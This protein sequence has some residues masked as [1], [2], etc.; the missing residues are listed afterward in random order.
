[1]NPL[2]NRNPLPNVTYSQ[3]Y[4]HVQYMVFQ[5][6]NSTSNAIQMSKASD[7]YYVVN[8]AMP[9]FLASCETEMHIW[10]YG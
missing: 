2:P 6:H 4:M 9:M 1:M 3:Y 7:Y 10:K 5:G 8:T